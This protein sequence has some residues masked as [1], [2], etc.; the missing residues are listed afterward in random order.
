M[1][2][3][4]KVLYAEACR[5]ALTLWFSTPVRA[6]R[7][8][9]LS[10]VDFGIQHPRLLAHM[11]SPPLPGRR[12]RKVSPVRAR[13]DVLCPV[14]AGQKEGAFKKGE[15]PV[16]WRMRVGPWCTGCRV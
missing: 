15:M 14:E 7:P 8:G 13:I 4:F 16:K 5:T 2:W 9:G 6:L 12:Q 3:R 11:R 1:R 10:Y